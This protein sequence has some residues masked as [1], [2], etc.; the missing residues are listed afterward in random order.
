MRSRLD[1]GE[2]RSEKTD[3]DANVVGKIKS[4]Q[5]SSSMPKSS[6]P[7]IS[8]TTTATRTITKGI[9]IGE[10][11]SSSK[12]PP[13]KKTVANKSKGKGI[14]IEPTPKEMMVAIEA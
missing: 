2:G 14:S 11:R 4:T 10:S 1:R 9:F 13:P 3:D 8:T 6:Y 5:I 12:P 7:I